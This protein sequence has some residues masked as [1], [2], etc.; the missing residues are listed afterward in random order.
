MTV[1]LVVSNQALNEISNKLVFEN[2]LNFYISFK[3]ISIII[4]N[5]TTKVTS[6]FTHT[7]KIYIY[8]IKM[9]SERAF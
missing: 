4:I 1:L 6:Q 9:L 7:K 3:Y 5:I 8:I 2:M